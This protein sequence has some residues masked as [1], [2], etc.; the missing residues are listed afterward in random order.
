MVLSI[1]CFRGLGMSYVVFLLLFLFLPIFN[2]TNL[3]LF[4][5]H[6]PHTNKTPSKMQ[7]YHTIQISNDNK[8]LGFHSEPLILLYKISNYT[9]CHRKTKQ[10]G[11]RTSWEPLNVWETSCYPHC[12]VCRHSFLSFSFKPLWSVTISFWHSVAYSFSLFI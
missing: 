7:R 4:N 3:Y 10:K 6:T 12:Y 11:L 2:F 9:R 5:S 1:N 8:W